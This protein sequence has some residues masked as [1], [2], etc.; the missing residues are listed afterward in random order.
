M[1]EPT[2]VYKLMNDRQY[3]E[4]KAYRLSADGQ[5]IGRVI[6]NHEGKFRAFLKRFDMDTGNFIGKFDT[7]P[8]AIEAIK[9]M[10]GMR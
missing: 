4:D 7:L 8:E 5:M 10:D 2:I 9:E 1:S 3:G 6:L